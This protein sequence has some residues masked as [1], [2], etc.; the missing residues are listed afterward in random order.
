MP[1]KGGSR[2]L[3]LFALFLSSAYAQ[4]PVYDALWWKQLSPDRKALY[5]E[6]YTQGSD[7]TE[8]LWSG[9]QS[10]AKTKLPMEVFENAQKLT[11]YAKV[12]PLRLQ[13]GMDTFYT[14]PANAHVPVA[15]VV[16]IVRYRLDGGSPAFLEQYIAALRRK[17]A[18]PAVR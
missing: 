8:R 7:V 9:A 16:F 12:S 3:A 18:N 2:A 1:L 14:D 5:L 6:G 11:S 13:S 4:I 10:T 15:S 17:T